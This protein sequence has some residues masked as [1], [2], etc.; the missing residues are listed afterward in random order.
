MSFLSRLLVQTEEDLQAVRKELSLVKRKATDTQN[1][2]LKLV[3]NIHNVASSSETVH[4]FRK[5]N[6]VYTNYKPRVVGRNE[7]LRNAAGKEDMFIQKRSE[8][9]DE[10]DYYMDGMYSKPRASILADRMMR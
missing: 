6:M 5:H 2:L 10:G 7:G 8:D 1:D 9:G 4:S 3:S